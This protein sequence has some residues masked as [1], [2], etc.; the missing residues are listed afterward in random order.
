VTSS[1]FWKANIWIRA[2]SRVFCRGAKYGSIPKL[3]EDGRFFCSASEKVSSGEEEGSESRGRGGEG[4]VSGWE[5]KWGGGG[6]SIRERGR[7]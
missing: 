2:K 3:E 4:W 1:F 5:R 6:I 7:G